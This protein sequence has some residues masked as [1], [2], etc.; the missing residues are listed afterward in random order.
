VAVNKWEGLDEY[1]RDQVKRDIARK[2]GFLDFARFHFIS[3]LEGQG[4]GDLF[5]SINAAYK[6]AMAKLPTPRL[7]RALQLAV[8]K[9]QPP[10]VGLV[11][12]KMKYAHQ[13]GMNPPVV[14]IHGTALEGVPDSYWRYLEHSFLKMFKL[15]G[16]PLRVQFKKGDNPYD[17]KPGEFKP[18]RKGAMRGEKKPVK[19]TAR[20]PAKKAG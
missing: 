12:P 15:Q 2:L 18:D 13:G 8:E 16:T 17:A 9:Q 3:A 5:A 14:V 1:R 19:T 4:V 20:K 10:R 7:T 6:A 11:R